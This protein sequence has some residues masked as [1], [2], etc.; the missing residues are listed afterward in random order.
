MPSADLEL[1]PTPLD[2]AFRDPA[3]GWM[4]FFR[5]PRFI[6]QDAYE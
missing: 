1:P 5:S 4:F 3:N 2:A 6:S